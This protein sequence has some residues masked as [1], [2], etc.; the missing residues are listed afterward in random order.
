MLGW[1][2]CS[3]VKSQQQYQTTSKPRH[4]LSSATSSQS[5]PVHSPSKNI[6]SFSCTHIKPKYSWIIA[7]TAI[8]CVRKLQ[9]VSHICTYCKS[10][11]IPPT[12]L[13]TRLL[14]LQYV[15]FSNSHQG[16]FPP[17]FVALKLTSHK[18]L[19]SHQAISLFPFERHCAD[20]CQI[21]ILLFIDF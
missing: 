3:V 21:A 10:V 14:F 13:L 8:V 16:D 15:S 19:S 5:P 18:G 4:P 6:S 1:F 11:C 2:L 7:P 20:T 17:Q 9:P 12:L